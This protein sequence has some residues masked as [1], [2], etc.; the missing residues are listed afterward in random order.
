MHQASVSRATHFALQPVAGRLQ[1]L[2]FWR[3]NT[4]DATSSA[5][6]P[7]LTALEQQSLGRAP[8][9]PASW[10]SNVLRADG[11]ELRTSCLCWALRA[12]HRGRCQARERVRESLGDLATV[13]LR[14]ASAARLSLDRAAS[15]ASWC[16]L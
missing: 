2:P 3:V 15:L 14:R 13:L 16:I 7:S 9:K 5:N 11:D 4:Q 1:A 6:K 12:S 10:G 8:E